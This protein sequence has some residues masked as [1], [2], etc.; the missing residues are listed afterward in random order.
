MTTLQNS[1][2]NRDQSAGIKDRDNLAFTVDSD[3]D[4]YEI[5]C[6]YSGQMIYIMY[7]KCNKNVFFIS[8]IWL[9]GDH[10]ISKWHQFYKL[11]QSNKEIQTGYF[12]FTSELPQ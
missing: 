4:M 7:S 10:E 11:I 8:F 12:K 6:E 9:T 3:L 5:F 1:T 2:T